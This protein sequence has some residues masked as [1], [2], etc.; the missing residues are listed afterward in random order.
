MYRAVRGTEL[1]KRFHSLPS[2]SKEDVEFNLLDIERVNIG[3]SF[4]VTIEILNKSDRP[5][6]IQAILSA[7]SVFYN[8]VKAKLIKKTTGDFTLQPYSSKIYYFTHE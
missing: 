1:A 8:G 2:S 6:T 7:G 3:D 5:R 4:S